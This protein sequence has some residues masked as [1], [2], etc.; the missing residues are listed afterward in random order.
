MRR[1]GADAP[2]GIETL[3]NMIVST[4]RC[5]RGG[6]RDLGKLWTSR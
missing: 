1:A 2:G 5:I 4:M 6:M 3:W